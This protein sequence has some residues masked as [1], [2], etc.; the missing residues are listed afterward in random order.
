MCAQLTPLIAYILGLRT[1]SFIEGV[2]SIEVFVECIKIVS[3]VSTI[4][5]VS[6]IEGV[7]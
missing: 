1:L 6:A 3:V 2:S 4:K 5:R 7:H